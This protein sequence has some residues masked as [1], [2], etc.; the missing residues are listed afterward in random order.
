MANPNG[1]NM[2]HEAMAAA[3]A[4][5]NSQRESLESLVGQITT[6]VDDLTNQDK[7]GSWKGSAASAFYTAYYE[8]KPALD[9]M[10]ALIGSLSTE[11]TKTNAAWTEFDQQN[12]SRYSGT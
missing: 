7:P 1:M 2:D 9:R 10:V 4:T 5:L 8:T 6:T 12:A 11:V 3:A